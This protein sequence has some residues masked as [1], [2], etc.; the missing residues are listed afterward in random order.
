MKVVFRVDA[1]LQIGN[2]HVMRCL[3]LADVLKKQGVHCSFICRFHDGNMITAIQQKGYTV[4]ILP[5]KEVIKTK[6]LSTGD[7]YLDWLGVEVSTDA[8]DTMKIVQSTE[9]RIDWIIVDHYALGTQWEKALRPHCKMI[10]VIDDLANRAHDCDL[11]L[12]QTF[13]RLPKDY[14]NLTSTNCVCLAGSQYALLRPEFSQMREY[15]LARR[16][17]PKLEQLLITLGG[18]DKDNVVSEVLE[19]LKYSDLPKTCYIVIVMGSNAPWLKEVKNKSKT[20]DWKTDVLVDVDNMAKLM[21]DSDLCIGA[22]G[23]TTWERCCLG[24][25]TLL[26]KLAENQEKIIK[27]L[28]KSESVLPL[29]SPLEIRKD[30]KYKF[31]ETTLYSLSARSRGICDGSGAEQVVKF[32]G[33][34]K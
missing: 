27:E 24:L 26:L 23:G 14:E 30:G 11:L 2:G 10:M 31:M 17:Q 20:M 28:S 3:T 1:S 6:V 25:P 12:D 32:L 19:N 9:S 21:A 34:T 18:V 8:E 33:N 7:D 13:G 15:S 5:I 16:E 22:A 29:K 4:F